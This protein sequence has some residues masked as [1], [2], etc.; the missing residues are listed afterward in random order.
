MQTQLSMS[1]PDVLAAD[2]AW[3]QLATVNAVTHENLMSGHYAAIP[4][5]R[6]QDA[7]NAAFLSSPA[8][9]ADNIIR[10]LE[11]AEFYLDETGQD[12]DRDVTCVVI[13]L[14]RQGELD[15]ALRYATAII[16]G[17][18]DDFCYE[19]IWAAI[20]DMN[21]LAAKPDSGT[22][23]AGIAVISTRLRVKMTHCQNPPPTVS[24]LNTK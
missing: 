20:A 24:L 15:H 21:R 22:E 23:M 10:K 11:L 17:D 12:A 9:T 1:S 19:P 8:D 18:A 13:A 7:V 16:A 4:S 5:L 6:I 2:V 14:V 3:R